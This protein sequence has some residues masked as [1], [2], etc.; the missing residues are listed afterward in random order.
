MRKDGLSDLAYRM[1]FEKIVPLKYESGILVLQLESQFIAEYI[2][3]NYISL[4][5]KALNRV[6]GAGTRLEYKVLIDRQS[7]ASITTP[8]PKVSQVQPAPQT[9]QRDQPELHTDS[10]D[11]DSQLNPAYTF[12]SFVQ[13]ECNKLART[14]GLS[15][16][17]N[18]GYTPF[19]PLF[20]YGGPGIGKTHLVNAIGNEIR[21]LKPHLR[22]LYLSANTFKMQFM[23]AARTNH[24][25]DFLAFY[26]SIDV[27]IVDDIQ[28]LASIERTQETFFH[29]FNHLHQLRKQI[30][31]TSDKAPLQLQGLE[32]RLLSRFK[33]GLPA[34]MQRPDFSLRK[35]IL[36][37]KAYRD[38]VELPEDVVN[39]IA[40]NVRDNVRDLEGVIASLLAFSTINNTE[41]TLEEAEKIVGGIVNITPSVISQEDIL[42]R[43]CQHNLIDVQSVLGTSRI[44]EVVRTRQ[45]AMYLCKKLT[46]ASLA[47]IG[48]FFGGKN[49]A[50][51]LH[52]IA[53]VEELINYDPVMK[54]MINKIEN[55]L[56]H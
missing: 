33:W 40:E 51:V 27:L 21:R 30:I 49:H 55:E 16:A 17:Q 42:K 44:R 53:M 38:G 9:I 35:D 41:I 3:E 14:A 19:N 54:R 2:E 56:I 23:D 34:E 37:S 7:G 29:V 11:F 48:A 45:V 6:F 52:A 15:I 4:L 31:L 8:S 43:V 47:E 25:A 5:G 22:V 50:T 20:V 1:W 46:G 39:F 10:A 13:G 24:V 32:E 28:F 18:P 36:K 26:Q 12:Q